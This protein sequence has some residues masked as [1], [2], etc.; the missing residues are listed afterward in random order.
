MGKGGFGER[1]GG[2]GGGRGGFRGGRGG[3]RG[4]FGGGAGFNQGPPAEVV[5]M[6]SFVHACEGEMVCKSINPKIP[7]FNAP[8]FLENKSQIGKVDEILGPL[9]EVYFTVKMQEGMIAK[10]F[11]ADDKVFIGTD[12]L[13]P[14]E[15]FL[16]KPKTVGKVGKPTGQQ[17]R[18]GSAR[19]GRGGSARGGARGARGGSSRGGGRGGFG[20]DRGGR[21]GGFGG[22]FSGGRGGRGG[23][24][25]RGGRVQEKRENMP[26]VLTTHQ[27]STSNAGSRGARFEHFPD[28]D[29]F[30]ALDR[31]R[32]AL[33]RRALLQPLL[34]V[35][36]SHQDEQQDE[37][38]SVG[39]DDN[40]SFGVSSSSSNSDEIAD[41]QEQEE[42]DDATIT[43]SF[44]RSR[45]DIYRL[46]IR[47][48]SE[49]LEDLAAII[50]ILRQINALYR[51]FNNSNHQLG[52]YLR[53]RRGRTRASRLYSSHSTSG[54]S[55]SD[56]SD[57]SDDE[58]QEDQ[59]EA[60]KLLEAG[61]EG[62][63][64][65][66]STDSANNKKQ[67]TLALLALIT[68]QYSHCSDDY[69]RRYLD[70]DGEYN[71]TLAIFA[72]ATYDDDDDEQGF[73][74]CRDIIAAAEEIYGLD[75][76]DEFQEAKEGALRKMLEKLTVIAKIRL[77]VR[78]L[79][80][81]PPVIR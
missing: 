16:P 6:G 31:Q 64:A 55:S 28:N 8:I 29:D 66:L 23:R 56:S 21:G 59:E 19:G 12:K 3:G 24:S 54:S 25:G 47:T 70:P 48:N 20:G 42:E 53:V 68:L 32:Q 63:Q 81:T 51:V 40:E 80:S 72:A 57:A 67:S 75:W 36:A 2:R 38:D 44:S 60:N 45:A 35:Q 41:G 73:K 5:P 50:R 74:S 37:D 22:G 26:V 30:S 69:L 61:L 1:G 17:G 33:G 58:D 14:L 49:I 13:L 15:R 43:E 71:P 11:K 65:V 52:G 79:D 10:S 77:R 46:A 7:Y 78:D 34:P 4:G 62:L 76:L 9:N 27:D 39:A 18:G